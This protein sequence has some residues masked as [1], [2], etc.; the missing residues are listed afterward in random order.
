[1]EKDFSWSNSL[2]WTSAG[3]GMESAGAADSQIQSIPLL[4]NH[5]ENIFYKISVA[6]LLAE[7]KAA[8]KYRAYCTS[9]KSGRQKEVSM[10]YFNH[11]WSTDL[12]FNGFKITY[13]DTNCSSEQQDY[14]NINQV[15]SLVNSHNTLKFQ[16]YCNLKM[17]KEIPSGSIAQEKKVLIAFNSK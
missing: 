9:S 16:A 14:M 6:L 11:I 15:I 10:S 7:N 3:V 13:F 17:S 2:S 1:M 8:A 4:S 12:S 5:K